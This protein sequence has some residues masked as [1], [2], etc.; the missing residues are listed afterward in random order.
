MRSSPSPSVVPADDQ[1]VY[2]V[3]DDFGD[4]GRC[5]RETD[6]ET[7][8]LETIITGMLSGEYSNPVRVVGF[9]TTGDWARDVSKDVADEIRRRCNLQREDAEVPPN[10]QDFMGRHED[11]DRMQLTLHLVRAVRAGD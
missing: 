3:M 5:W 7:A 8:D 6:E 4:L 2:L 9:N 11:R 10:L 1:T